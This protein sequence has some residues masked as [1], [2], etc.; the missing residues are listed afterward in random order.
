[1]ETFALRPA[2]YFGDDALSALEALAGK[3]V[4]IVTDDFLAH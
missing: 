3:R 2:I 4:L 1:M